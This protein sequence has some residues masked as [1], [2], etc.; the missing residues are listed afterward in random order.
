MIEIV[1]EMFVS[2][3]KG[4]VILI[5]ILIALFIGAML[6]I[7][8]SKS[9]SDEYKSKKLIQPKVVIDIKIIDGVQTSDTTYI[10]NLD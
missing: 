3:F 9:E 7:H 1:G 5:L 4:I 8:S 10:Y 2:F 6:W